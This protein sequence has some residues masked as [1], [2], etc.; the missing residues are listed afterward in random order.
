MMKITVETT[1]DAPIEKV[2]RA[3]NNPKDILYWN[4]ASEDWHTTSSTVDLRV[5]GIFCSRMEAKDG[6]AGFDFEGTYTKIVPQ[7]LI[8]YSFGDRMAQITFKDSPQGVVV[9]V[10]FDSESTNSIEMQRDGWQSILNNFKKH[11]EKSRV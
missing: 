7:E 4:A 3:Y 1:V 10:S 8:E 2:W 5:G 6:S 9:Q 11:V